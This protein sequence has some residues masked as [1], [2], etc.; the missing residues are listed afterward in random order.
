LLSHTFPN[1]GFNAP[2]TLTLR[3]QA[4][5]AGIGDGAA[6]GGT[7]GHSGGGENESGLLGK[8]HRPSFPW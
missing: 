4:F 8:V 3:P 5:T 6:R 7:R 2:M 1:A